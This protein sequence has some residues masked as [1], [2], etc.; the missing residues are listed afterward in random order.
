MLAFVNSRY[1]KGSR[2]TPSVT[3]P[4]NDV[5]LVIHG[6]KTSRHSAPLE[7][8]PRAVWMS[9]WTAFKMNLQTTLADCFGQAS[10]VMAT[11]FDTRSP[12]TSGAAHHIT[13]GSDGRANRR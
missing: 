6:A 4:D 10:G 9:S 5:W 2:I 13:R 7:L 11:G 3:L 12:R 8:H 1:A